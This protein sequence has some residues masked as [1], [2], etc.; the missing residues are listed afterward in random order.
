MVRTKSLK[1]SYMVHWIKQ[2]RSNQNQG[3]KLITQS[4]VGAGVE[5]TAFSQTGFPFP[6]KPWVCNGRLISR[7][8]EPLLKDQQPFHGIRL[9]PTS[10]QKYGKVMQMLTRHIVR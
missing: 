8:L 1:Q 10:K 6:L 3:Q 2:V 7:Y 4:F 5:T 9:P